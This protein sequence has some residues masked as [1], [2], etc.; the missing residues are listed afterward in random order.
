MDKL[1]MPVGS[2][3]LLEA[4][5]AVVRGDKYIEKRNDLGWAFVGGP[6]LVA[7]TTLLTIGSGLV[8][9]QCW[10]DS[11]VLL[12]D[13]HH[14]YWLTI[15]FGVVSVFFALLTLAGSYLSLKDMISYLRMVFAKEYA[16]RRMPT[17]E[18][19]LQDKLTLVA[20]ELAR[21][22]E[23]HNALATELN[24]QEDLAKDGL[25]TDMDL[26]RGQLIAHALR[27]YLDPKL[28]QLDVLIRR[29]N[30]RA[31]GQQVDLAD[32]REVLDDR[33]NSVLAEL[34]TEQ[35]MGGDAAV[36]TLHSALLSDD[37]NEKL[38]DP[39]AIGRRLAAR[40]STA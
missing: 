8:A 16:H 7:L 30:H 10:V 36:S 37:V 35:E 13:M 23:M 12:F 28:S 21:Q 33:Y 31:S 18:A 32:M 29:R 24:L 25:P 4:H 27:E 20:V 40:R 34:R 6:I 3:E 15:S 14:N 2:A 1:E 9:E 38:G 22:V 17:E 26:E 39:A 19:L 11:P 5:A